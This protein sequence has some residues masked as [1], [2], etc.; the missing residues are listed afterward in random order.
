[1]PLDAIIGAIALF[2]GLLSQIPPNWQLC[3]GTNGTPD[4]TSRFL[5]GAGN[6]YGVE[7][8]GGSSTHTHSFSV[9]DH[10]HEFKSGAD[11]GSGSII[12]TTT[13]SE[14]DFGSTNPGT[15]L[16]N[17]YKVAFIQRIS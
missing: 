1:M 5:V 14:E 8:T 16:P 17:Y 3:D 10:T 15:S 6:G 11:I 7:E 9:A 13:R 2:G 4:M 12:G